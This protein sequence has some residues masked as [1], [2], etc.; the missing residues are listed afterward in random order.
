MGDENSSAHTKALN[1]VFS[2]VFEPLP[3]RKPEGQSDD[4]PVGLG[5]SAKLRAAWG[6]SNG[7]FRSMLRSR[8]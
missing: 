8:Q 7:G 2:L 1:R 3:K 5:G 6:H 4:Q